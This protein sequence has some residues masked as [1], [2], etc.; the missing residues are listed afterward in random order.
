MT[1]AWESVRLEQVLKRKKSEIDVDDTQ[2][3]KRLTIRIKGL[4][5]EVRDQVLGIQIGTKRQ[6]LVD[7]GQFILSK[8]DARNGAFGVIPKI[9][10][11][12]IITGNFWV[13]DV[14]NTRLDAQYFN[15]LTKT[16]QFIEFCIRASEG[17]TNRLYLQESKFLEQEIPLPPLEEQKRIVA[18]VE[19]L[20]AQIAEAR[21]LREKASEERE[22][23]D[24]RIAARVFD[25]PL[26]DRKSVGELCEVR[27]GIQKS[28]NRLPGANPRRYITVAHVQ[29]NRIDTSDPRYFEVNAEEF[30]RWKLESGDVLVIEGNG[31]KDHI[32]RAALFTGQ[33]EDC[34]HQN[35]V[36]RVRPDQKFIQ[37]EFLNAYFNSPVGREQMLERSRTSSGLYTLSTGRVREIVVPLPTLEQQTDVVRIL[38]DYKSQLSSLEKLQEATRLELN[39]LLPSVLSKAFAGEL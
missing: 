34:V 33:I 1:Q 38:K 35:H 29:R 32:G 4:G 6:F 31:S 7:E 2:Q 9:C 19:N 23:L 18:R 10:A 26:W 20:A 24:H 15:F 30:E 12:G 28:A 14:I 22:F 36:I 13:F 27:S 3:Y 39:A 25:N 11:G 8:I 17:S 16:H 21:G 37:P 5:V